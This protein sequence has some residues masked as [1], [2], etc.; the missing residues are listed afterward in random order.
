M[1]LKTLSICWQFLYSRI[2]ISSSEFSPEFQILKYN[3][4]FRSLLWC[5][6]IMTILTENQNIWFYS[7][8]SSKTIPSNRSFH[9]SWWQFHCLSWS[10]WKE[11]I[12]GSLFLWAHWIC[13]KILLDFFKVSP[14]SNHFWPLP[15]PGVSWHHLSP[16]TFP[17]HFLSPRPLQAPSHWSS[18][19][20]HASLYLFSI[21]PLEWSLKH[22][23]STVSLL[24]IFLHLTYGKTQ[25][26]HDS[27]Q[28]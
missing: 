4:P 15:L 20:Y 25:E 11:I 16:S 27:L 2:N 14:E 18:C 19:I 21:Q 1:W 24:C 5:P 12:P 13:Q 8:H 3:S 23:S 10:D 7:N 22:T 6:I 17:K 26:S 9:L 28:G